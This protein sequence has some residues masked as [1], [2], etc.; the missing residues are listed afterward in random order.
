MELLVLGAIIE[1]SGENPKEKK[2]LDSF[3][4][5][6]FTIQK[7]STRL[8]MFA[9]TISPLGLVCFKSILEIYN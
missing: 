2:V 8:C 5:S 1:T 9:R 6:I 7:N 4:N 3:P